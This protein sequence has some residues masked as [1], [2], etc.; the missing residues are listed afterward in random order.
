MNNAQFDTMRNDLHANAQT[1][2][3]MAVSLEGV[4]KTGAIVWHALADRLFDALAQADHMGK[5]ITPTKP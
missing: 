4:R 2:R 1:A 3:E 5:V